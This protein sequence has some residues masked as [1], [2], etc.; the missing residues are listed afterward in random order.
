MPAEADMSNWSIL[1]SFDI[2]FF[3][4]YFYIFIREKQYFFLPI[5]YISKTHPIIIFL[6]I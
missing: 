3:Y 1:N 5:N 4:Y 2:F 6:V